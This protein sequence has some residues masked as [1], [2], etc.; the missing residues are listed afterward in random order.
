MRMLWKEC[1][2]RKSFA[3]AQLLY[4]S[5]NFFKRVIATLIIHNL[6]LS[7]IIIISTS[8][9]KLSAILILFTTAVVGIASAA[10]V[11]HHG[12]IYFSFWCE[13]M[14][15]WR[16]R[17]SWVCCY[18][19]ALCLSFTLLQLLLWSLTTHRHRRFLPFVAN[20]TDYR[21]RQSTRHR[22]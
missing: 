2:H 21:H 14:W 10:E 4:I 3:V 5:H 15:W 7:T 8:N 16:K 6:L 1:Q 22:R 17:R 12:H 19:C 20:V 9:M 13:M 18:V 11:S